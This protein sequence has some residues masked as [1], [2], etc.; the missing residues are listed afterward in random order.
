MNFRNEMKSQ[1]GIRRK[2]NNNNAYRIT[3]S[4]FWNTKFYYSK[5]PV[6][7]YFILISLNSLCNRTYRSDKWEQTSEHE[8]LSQLIKQSLTLDNYVQRLETETKLRTAFHNRF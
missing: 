3:K 4:E 6:S 2:S 1:C 8:E 7:I 5:L